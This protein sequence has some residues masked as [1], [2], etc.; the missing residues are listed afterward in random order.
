MHQAI[1]RCY[2][3]MLSKNDGSISKNRSSGNRL[4]IKS[5]RILKFT[6]LIPFRAGCFHVRR[7]FQHALTA[8]HIDIR[9]ISISGFNLFR[10]QDG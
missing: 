10:R 4:R 8:F 2:S 7:V 3:L 6:I 5:S 9:N 1:T